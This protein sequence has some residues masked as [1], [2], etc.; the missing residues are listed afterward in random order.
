MP[1]QE[2]KRLAV[3]DLMLGTEPRRASVQFEEQIKSMRQ[4]SLTE[5]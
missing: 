3:A 2:I 1:T 5:L 4:K